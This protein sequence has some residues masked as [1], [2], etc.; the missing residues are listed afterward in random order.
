MT[1]SK[2]LNSIIANPKQHQLTAPVTQHQPV[3]RH[4]RL[5][6]SIQQQLVPLQRLLESRRHECI[7]RSRVDQDLEMDPEDDEVDDKREDDQ[8]P[9]SSEKVSGKVG[10]RGATPTSYDIS[11]LFHS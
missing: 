1:V 8:R 6:L 10:L 3:R 2:Y 11:L 5:T 4:R 9:S 7:T